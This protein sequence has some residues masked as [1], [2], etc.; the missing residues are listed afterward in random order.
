L[1]EGNPGANIALCKSLKLP[2]DGKLNY[3]GVQTVDDN[4]NS[5]CRLLIRGCVLPERPNQKRIAA[6]AEATRNRFLSN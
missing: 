5:Q 3:C 1:K 4:L 6:K 2:W